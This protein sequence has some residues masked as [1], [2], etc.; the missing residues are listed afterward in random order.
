MCLLVLNIRSEL[1]HVAQDA[2]QIGYIDAAL[3]PPQLEYWNSRHR[4]YLSRVAGTVVEDGLGRFFLR[5]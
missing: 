5:I 4:G 1:P 2:A 3:A